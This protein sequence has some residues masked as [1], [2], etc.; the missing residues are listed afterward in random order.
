MATKAIVNKCNSKQKFV[1]NSGRLVIDPQW[2]TLPTSYRVFKKPIPVGFRITWQTTA[3]FVNTWKPQSIRDK[4]KEDLYT[5]SQGFSNGRHVLEIIPNGDGDVPVNCLVV[6]QPAPPAAAE[7]A[8]L[9]ASPYVV[10]PAFTPLR[11]GAV[12]PRG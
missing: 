8:T 10:Q 6:Y 9:Q 7:S 11:F 2:F 5:L 3:Q 12:R 4:T 1:S